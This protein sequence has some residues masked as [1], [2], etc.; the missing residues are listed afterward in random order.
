M[1]NFSGD[2]FSNERWP[3]HCCVP[4]FVHAALRA[5]GIDLKEPAS[6]PA[7]LGVH[8]GANDEN[9][10]DLQIAETDDARGVTVAV[11]EKSIQAL[12]D[13]LKLSI[14]FRYLPFNEIPLSLYEDVLQDAL[15]KGFIVG[16]GADV[17]QLDIENCQGKALHVF[18]VVG[19]NYNSITLFDDA[20]ECY[21]PE[22]TRAWHEV[23]RSVLAAESGFWI[24]G[25]KAELALTFTQFSSRTIRNSY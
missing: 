20:Y 24:F 5:S 10:L 22:L 21:P 18:R 1:R 16:L 13:D 11:A 25:P 17:S 7:L 6:L 2:C 15:N 14:S 23:E 8:V 12:L 4:A 3:A 19:F 9:P